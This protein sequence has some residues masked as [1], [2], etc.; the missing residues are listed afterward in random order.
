MDKDKR[1]LSVTQYVRQHLARSTLKA[2]NFYVYFNYSLSEGIERLR[3]TLVSLSTDSQLGDPARSCLKRGD[4]FENNSVKLY[5]ERKK[6]KVEG[7]I[8]AEISLSMAS[9]NLD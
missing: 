4:F 6:R 9:K 1:R 5:F 7:K 3:Q 2:K 8:N